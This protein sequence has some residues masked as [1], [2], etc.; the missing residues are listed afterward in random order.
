MSLK[1]LVQR[2]QIED[3]AIKKATDAEQGFA[4]FAHLN[5]LS[6]DVHNIRLYEVDL[7]ETSIV[8]ITSKKGIIDI[9]NADQEQTSLFLYLKNPE[10]TT[11]R[12]KF[13]NQL[14]VY[15]TNGSVTPIVIGRG[16]ADDEFLIEIKN[17]SEAADW[18]ALYV[19]YEL[20]KID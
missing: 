13:Y 14:S 2:Q 17:L 12:H 16:Y 6:E 11:D 3:P 19:Y 9:E 5:A 7:S 20:V 1:K 18:G 8:R 15:T 4:R 10:I